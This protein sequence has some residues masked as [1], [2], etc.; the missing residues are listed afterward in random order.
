MLQ[1]AANNGTERRWNRDV[2]FVTHLIG[3]M[4]SISSH[5]KRD[6]DEKEATGIRDPDSD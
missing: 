6:F 1:G 3:V 2:D 5:W 4:R